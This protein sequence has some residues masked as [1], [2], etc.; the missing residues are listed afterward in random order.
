MSPAKRGYTEGMKPSDFFSQ[1]QFEN[2]CRD[3]FHTATRRQAL[4]MKTGQL[5]LSPYRLLVQIGLLGPEFG[6]QCIL[7]YPLLTALNLCSLAFCQKK[8]VDLDL[9]LKSERKIHHQLLGLPTGDPE[10]YTCHE[11]WVKRITVDLGPVYEDEQLEIYILDKALKIHSNLYPAEKIP[12]DKHKTAILKRESTRFKFTALTP[13][14]LHMEKDESETTLGPI[15]PLLSDST[16][17]T[18]VNDQ[19]YLVKS[20]GYLVKSS[21]LEIAN[22]VAPA[23][24]PPQLIGDISAPHLIP[25][26]EAHLPLPHMKRYNTE[27]LLMGAG[28]VKIK[29]EI[30]G[31]QG[32]STSQLNI[33]K[34]LFHHTFYHP[35]LK[36]AFGSS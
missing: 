20:A 7:D 32:F 21:L 1:T 29:L 27:V 5:N 19:Q 14:S 26:R 11:T 4:G 6:G 24:I 23:F 13:T 31:I 2:L 22:Q 35:A 33:L 34:D 3:T 9:N 8:F 30:G 18:T 15:P 12:L 17:L 16:L 10:T 36:K 28:P 25:S